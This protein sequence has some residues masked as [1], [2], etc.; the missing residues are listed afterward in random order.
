[1]RYSCHLHFAQ[2]ASI[3]KRLVSII[4]IVAL[5]SQ[6]AIAVEPQDFSSLPARTPEQFLSE[7]HDIVNHGD[8]ADNRFVSKKIRIELI[9][10]DAVRAKNRIGDY[11]GVVNQEYLPRSRSNE[12]LDVK[13][14]NV[15]H[16][17]KYTKY[18]EGQ[19]P[20]DVIAWFPLDTGTICI[21]RKHV[22]NSFGLTKSTENLNQPVVSY[23]YPLGKS[24]SIIVIFLFKQ[25][26]CAQA[27]QLYQN[28]DEER[29]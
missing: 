16:R 7:I 17:I 22:E 20:T 4:P 15:Y 3:R 1:M 11:T 8:L 2:R 5:L 27:V 10:G 29:E 24:V 23:Q 9:P 14:G 21:S 18:F 6:F 13:D 12:F 28:R 19:K 25:E 26:Q